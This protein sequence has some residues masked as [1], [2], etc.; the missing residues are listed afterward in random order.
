MRLRRSVDARDATAATGSATTARTAGRIA[1]REPPSDAPTR[2]F[3]SLDE[4]VARVGLRRDEL[5]TLA[6]IGAL[7]AFGYDRRSALW[8]VEQAVRPSGELFTTLNAEHTEPQNMLFE[9]EDN[10]G[11]RDSASHEPRVADADQTPAPPDDRGRA[12]GRRL[13]RHRPLDRPP[14]DGA[15]ARRAGDARHPARQRSARGA[16]GPPRAGRRHGDYPPAAGDGQRLRVPH[17]S[18]TKPASPT[19]SCGRIC[20]PAIAS[21]SSRSR[22]SSWTACCRARMASPRSAPRR[23]RGLP[24]AGVDFEAH[25]FTS[26]PCCHG[27]RHRGPR[28]RLAS[29]LAV[30]SIPRTR[31][32][33]V[34]AQRSGQISDFCQ[35]FR[36]ASRLRFHQAADASRRLISENSHATYGTARGD[37]TGGVGHGTS[38][39]RCSPA[40]MRLQRAR[41]RS[42]GHRG[43]FPEHPG[44]TSGRSRSCTR[45]KWASRNWACG[46]GRSSAPKDRVSAAAATSDCLTADSADCR[47]ADA[48]PTDG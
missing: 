10:C 21:S 29:S 25:D 47:L 18:R 16:A 3:A 35:Q 45:S 5:V 31:A 38:R 33:S 43:V 48:R 30:C 2:R 36:V 7:N 4:L 40:T 44:P 23:S 12:A 42:P 17:A 15:A 14:S 22:F 27:D 20:S 26:M 13:R 46:A 32:C 28:Q 6:D 1:S 8:Q 41:H 34:S 11:L 9:E 19:S 24:G 37:R 39:S